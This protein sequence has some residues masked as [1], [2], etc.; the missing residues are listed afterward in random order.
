M[1]KI[2]GAGSQG[3]HVD[4]TNTPLGLGGN[5]HRVY[6]STL[7]LNESIATVM[8][9]GGKV[10]ERHEFPSVGPC[11]VCQDD[12][13][14]IFALQEP[15]EN[16]KSHA[17]NPPKGSVPGD[18]FFFSLPV[19]DEQKARTFFSN[20]LGWTFNEKG[21]EGGLGIANLKGPDGGLGC[22]RVGH[23]PSF[24]FRVDDVQRA[25]QAVTKAGG[26]AGDVFQAPEGIMSECVDNQG[27]TFG[28]VKPAQGY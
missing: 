28:I 26:T 20:V 7:D 19:Q 1:W 22:G 11:A 25:T 17:E 24:W 16:L 18:L 14:T 9:F 3:G 8:K 2:E 23:T 6:F 5:E 15:L 21:K 12:Q 10:V 13:G 4:G 27:V